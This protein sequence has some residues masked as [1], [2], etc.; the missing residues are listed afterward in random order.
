MSKGGLLFIFGQSSMPSRK[1]N[2][3]D[4]QAGTEEMQMTAK[5]E[6]VRAESRGWGSDHHHY[7]FI[8]CGEKT[9]LENRVSGG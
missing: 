6:K 5:E 7:Y 8:H 9:C 4:R 1:A 2:Y 3:S